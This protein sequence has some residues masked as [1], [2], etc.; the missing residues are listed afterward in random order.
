MAKK[1]RKKQSKAI[2]VLIAI[3]LIIIIGGIGLGTGI[4]RKY[5]YSNETMDLKKYFNI[6]KNDEI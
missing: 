3:A 2:P 1:R 6:E 5:S 4:L